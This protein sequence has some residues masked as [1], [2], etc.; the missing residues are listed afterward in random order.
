MVADRSVW[1]PPG[2]GSITFVTEVLANGPAVSRRRWVKA[3]F[4]QPNPYGHPNPNA[5][6]ELSGVGAQ[7]W[8]TDQHGTITISFTEQGPVVDPQR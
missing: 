5:L 6:A 1:F 7:I 8:R 2:E 3:A 4:G